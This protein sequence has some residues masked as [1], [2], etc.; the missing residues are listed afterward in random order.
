VKHLNIKRRVKKFHRQEIC[1]LWNTLILSEGL[2]NF[3]GRKF[4]ICETLKYKA[5]ARSFALIVI[6]QAWC[7]HQCANYLPA[8]EPLPVVQ[9]RFRGPRIW[10]TSEESQSYWVVFILICDCLSLSIRKQEVSREFTESVVTSHSPTS[11]HGH[12]TRLACQAMLPHQV[13]ELMP[14][15]QTQIFLYHWK[16]I[17]NVEVKGPPDSICYHYSTSTLTSLFLKILHFLVHKLA[18]FS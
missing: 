18:W 11:L 6:Q 3:T 15:L 9:F 7:Y 5:K 13:Q 4:V 16:L 10:H 1:D 14:P 17:D 8:A 2:K 12:L